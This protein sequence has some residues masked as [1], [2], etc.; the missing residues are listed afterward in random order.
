MLSSRRF[1]NEALVE[2]SLVGTPEASRQRS[3]TTS[4]RSTFRRLLC[5][6]WSLAYFFDLF[7]VRTST[8]RFFLLRIPYYIKFELVKATSYKWR[9]ATLERGFIVGTFLWWKTHFF[10]N[11][12]FRREKMFLISLVKP[13]LIKLTF[14][15]TIA[16][17][18]NVHFRV[19]NFF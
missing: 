1:G 13:V 7:V 2:F 17:D 11:G 15:I 6:R 5:C 9:V 18:S 4:G 10:N 16:Q 3:S 19:F 8:S 14:L 12:N